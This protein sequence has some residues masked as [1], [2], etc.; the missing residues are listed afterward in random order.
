MAFSSAGT[1]LQMVELVDH[2][3]RLATKAVRSYQTASDI[4]LP[5]IK[6]PHRIRFVEQ[7]RP[8]EQV[9]L[10][11]PDGTNQPT[12][13]PGKMSIIPRPPEL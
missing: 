11:D 5:L 1:L 9:V 6:K 10:P 3:D 4:L 12:I 2:P 8:M 13:S 7:T